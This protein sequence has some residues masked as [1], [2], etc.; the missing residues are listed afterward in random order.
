MWQRGDVHGCRRA[1]LGSL[2]ITGAVVLSG[3]GN[4][5]QPVRVGGP[6]VEASVGDVQLRNVRLDNPPA[7]I[8]EIGSAALLGVAMVNEGD[9][10][11]Q[12]VG[13]SG[14]DFTGAVV[15]ENPAS[16]DPAITVPAGETVFTDGPDGPVLV[17]VGID[18]TLRSSESLPVTF[19]FEPAGEVT[20]D[21][22][23][24][25]PLQLTLD[26]FLRERAA[27]D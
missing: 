13:V 7:G 26:R 22:P 5:E 6:G 1:V 9:E 21:V 4:D 15:D 25:A 23:V 19:T 12:L 17:L 18:E 3:C 20:V 16:S 10:D 27:G 24:S 11:E 8:Y 2:V 14:P